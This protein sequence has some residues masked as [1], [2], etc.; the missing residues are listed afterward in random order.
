MEIFLLK[1][2]KMTAKI[3]KLR[4]FCSKISFSLFGKKLYLCIEKDK[5]H[6]DKRNGRRL[7][8]QVFYHAPCTKTSKIQEW[9]GRK[10]YLSRYM[11]KSEIIF[12]A[13]SAFE[14]AVKHEILEGF[15]YNGIIVINPHI[16]FK[17]LLKVSKF[18]VQ[19]KQIENFDI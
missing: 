2:N 12:T 16:D 17:K 8:M 5:K 1:N 14:A 9:K 10:W 11:T 18:E 4:K 15:R 13:Y 3:K 19:R 6:K 7:Y